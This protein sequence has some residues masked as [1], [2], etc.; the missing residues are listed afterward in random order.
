MV[1]TY[2]S[3]EHEVF[4]IIN[5]FPILESVFDELKLDISNI[6][7]YITLRSFLEAKNLVEEEIK[8]IVN[9]LNQQINHFL[10]NGSL[11]EPKILK[12]SSEILDIEMI[13][14]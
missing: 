4:E 7:E 1:Q 14:I 8:F 12:Q 13:Q 9:K 3:S 5:Q 2:I 10:E 6:G 11:M